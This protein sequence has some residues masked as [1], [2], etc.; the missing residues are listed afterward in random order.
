MELRSCRLLSGI[1]EIGRGLL[2]TTL[3]WKEYGVLSMRFTAIRSTYIGIVACTVLKKGL[4]D[5]FID[6]LFY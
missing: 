3:T 2:S 6:V 1:S 4:F 5:V